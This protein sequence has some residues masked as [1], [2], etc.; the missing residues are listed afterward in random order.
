MFVT[1]TDEYLDLLKRIKDKTTREAALAEL[2]R[3]S[4]E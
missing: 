4:L 1:R 2:K 3:R